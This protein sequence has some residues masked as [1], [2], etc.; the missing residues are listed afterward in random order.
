MPEGDV[1]LRVARRLDQAL[2]TGALTRSELRWAE[3]GG[4]DL[5]GEH[6]T[7]VVSHGKHLLIRTG[8]GHTVHSHL[9]MDGS[10]QIEHTRTPPRP[11]GHWRIRAVLATSRWTCVGRDLGMLAV[12]PTHAEHRVL[13]HVGP[14]LMAADQDLAQARANALAEGSRPIG[15]TLL[16]Q[17]VAAGI[18]TIYLAETLWIHRISPW[19]PV[20]AVA[21]VGA[22]YGTAT[23]LMRRSAD[24]PQLTATGELAPGRRTHVHDR[25]GL[26]CRRCGHPIDVGQIGS[27]PQAR[28]GFFCPAC[29]EN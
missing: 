15:E 9:R 26:G 4:V 6:V 12:V 16:D 21:D 27:P 7:A 23:A 25:A 8:S 13:G 28:P 20:S 17:R 5:T 11:L 22:V 3:L 24:A 14:D 19:R 10:W 2:G 29:Q 18:G 1:A